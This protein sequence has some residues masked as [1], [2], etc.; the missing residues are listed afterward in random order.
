[1]VPF[2]PGSEADWPLLP[3]QS[4]NGSR[5]PPF[6]AAEDNQPQTRQAPHLDLEPLDSAST[7]PL[8][9]A[10]DCGMLTPDASDTSKGTMGFAPVL[11]ITNRITAELTRI[12]RARGFLEAAT[13]SDAWVRDMA[14]RAFVLEAH[15]TT[16]I[17]GTRLTIAQSAIRQNSRHTHDRTR[18]TRATELATRCDVEL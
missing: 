17:E 13:L 11:T 14:R 1:M 16:H 5:P 2:A 7:P 10:P 4:T 3:A 6:L 12:E 9:P 15:H 8:R 18:V